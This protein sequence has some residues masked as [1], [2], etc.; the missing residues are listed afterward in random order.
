MLMVM[1]RMLMVLVTVG[2]ASAVA[3]LAWLAGLQAWPAL[4]AIAWVIL[5][6]EGIALNF[7]TLLAFRC[8][9]PSVDMPA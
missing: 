7:G 2:I 4:A 8:F 9:D 5:L 1:L 6:G 3:L